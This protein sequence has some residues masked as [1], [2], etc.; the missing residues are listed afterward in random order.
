M[1]PARPRVGRFLGDRAWGRILFAADRRPIVSAKERREVPIG[2]ASIELWLQSSG[3]GDANQPDLVVLRLLGARGRAELA[4]LDPARYLPSATSLVA[5]M[6]PAGFGGARGTCT[7]SR[8]FNGVWAAYD[9]LAARFPCAA[10]WVYGKSIGGLG[11][12]FL[13]A[14]R[15]PHAIVVRNV[16]DVPS[17]AGE[18]AGRSIRAMV[19]EALDAKRWAV[20]AQCPALFVISGADRLARPAIQ[21][22]VVAAYAGRAETLEVSG[23]HDDREFTAPDVSRYE[24]ALSLLWKQPSYTREAVTFRRTP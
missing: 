24:K 2:S 19:P 15:S 23:A 4:T 10:I 13:A 12:L 17:I 20:H 18:R 8:Y 21:R 16:V 3:P 1:G 14:T 9:F 22:G 6:H 5:A 7:L 11:A